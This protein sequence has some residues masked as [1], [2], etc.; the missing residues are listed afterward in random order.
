MPRDSYWRI[1]HAFTSGVA[2]ATPIDG[3]IGPELPTANGQGYTLEVW[4]TAKS[5]SPSGAWPDAATRWETL[6]RIGGPASATVVHDM[7]G[8]QPHAYT[9]VG[10]A[11]GIGG[12]LVTIHPPVGSECGHGGHYACTSV[13]ETGSPA[14][15]A[16]VEM[17]LTRLASLADYP[18]RAAARES[19]ESP[20]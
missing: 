19:L 17:E 13:A 10:A 16:S 4:S 20:I 11:G 6:Q 9:V 5:D 12:G 7:P 8:D 2:S 18:D 3:H 15:V 14:H 1:E